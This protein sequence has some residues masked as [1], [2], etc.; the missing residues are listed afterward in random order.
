MCYLFLSQGIY[1]EL[2]LLFHLI[3]I[4]ITRYLHVLATFPRQDTKS[5]VHI[6]LCNRNWLYQNRI[7]REEKTMLH[8]WIA[9]LVSI[10]TCVG[11]IRTVNLNCFYQI[12]MMC[13]VYIVL[14]KTLNGIE[15]ECFTILVMRMMTR[16][17]TYS[18]SAIKLLS[19]IVQLCG[20]WDILRMHGR[21]KS[22]W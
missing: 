11:C 13:S 9:I 7:G 3:H 10:T 12:L 22:I 6:S 14:V 4:F 16:Y 19:M 21:S 1:F 2:H 15:Y 8:L 5:H 17:V 20:R 18:S